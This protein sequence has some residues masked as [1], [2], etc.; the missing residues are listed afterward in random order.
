MRF[1]LTHSRLRDD[2]GLCGA[3]G[4]EWFG[5]D[6]WIKPM[7]QIVYKQG[8]SRSRGDTAG[9]PHPFDRRSYQQAPQPPDDRRHRPSNPQTKQKIAEPPGPKDVP[10]D[11]VQ[12]MMTRTAK[13]CQAATTVRR[14]LYL[15]TRPQ[16]PRSEGASTTSATASSS[17]A[18]VI[19][20]IV[21][22]TLSGL[23]VENQKRGRMAA[24]S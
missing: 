21:R 20:S 2:P 9:Q 1:P 14:P 12:F 3:F 15:G 6:I 16:I 13:V 8:S 24:N 22:L 18:P 4:S 19:G 11:M 7:K 17:A 5:M 23:R 10:R